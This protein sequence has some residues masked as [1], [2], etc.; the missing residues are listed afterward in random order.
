MIQAHSI[1]ELADKLEKSI[2][3]AFKQQPD[4]ET[5]KFG[6]YKVRGSKGN[7]YEVRLGQTDTGAYFV[8]CLCL[9]SLHTGKC[10]HS[11]AAFIHHQI[12]R[13]E[14]LEQ[15]EKSALD[16]GKDAPYLKASDEKKPERVGGVRI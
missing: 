4:I 6:H 12:T 13:L 15:K 9:G 16:V 3:K 10:F 7:W 14:M 11:A 8:A 5:I 2:Q 1:T